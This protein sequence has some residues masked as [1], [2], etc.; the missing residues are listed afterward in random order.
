MAHPRI[1]PTCP[2]LSWPPPADAH[3]RLVHDGGWRRHALPHREHLQHG[4]QAGCVGPLGR[5]APVK[6]TGAWLQGCRPCAPRLAACRG[7][8]HT[9]RTAG[10]RG[11]KACAPA[12][13]GWPLRR[14][15]GCAAPPESD[16]SPQRCRR[17]GGQAAMP[18]PW[19]GRTWRRGEAGEHNAASGMCCARRWPAA[20]SGQCPLPA[21][22]PPLP[23]GGCS[24][25]AAAAHAERAW[26][27]HRQGPHDRPLVLPAAGRCRAALRLRICLLPPMQVLATRGAA[28]AGLRSRPAGA[29]A[30]RAA[31]CQ[32]RGRRGA[33]RRHAPVAAGQ[34]GC[35]IQHL[36]R[37]AVRLGGRIVVAPCGPHCGGQG[38]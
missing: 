5:T 28:T 10:W 7:W 2:S 16:M 32:A 27:A 29:N 19:V 24:P 25:R 36:H 8:L 12:L 30:K 23:P 20:R 22:S 34:L 3:R 6:R 35:H 15:L 31:G 26:Q 9:R 21:T 37:A 14:S 4:S 18:V 17:A 38:W 1:K 33:P 11:R 13:P